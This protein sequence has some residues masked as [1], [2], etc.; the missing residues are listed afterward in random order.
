MNFLQLENLFQ[1]RNFDENQKKIKCRV[2]INFDETKEMTMAELLE[3]LGELDKGK[4]SE[5]IVP[6]QFYYNNLTQETR[7]GVVN[8]QREFVKFL[9]HLYC[10][11]RRIEIKME[12]AGY[13]DI[14]PDLDPDE[15]SWNNICAKLELA[16]ENYKLA[17]KYDYLGVYPILKE[18]FSSYIRY[19]RYSMENSINLNEDKC[20]PET[21]GAMKLWLQK[22]CIWI[23]AEFNGEWT[24][25]TNSFIGTP[26]GFDEV[27][28]TL[29]R[30]IKFSDYPMQN[31]NE[32]VEPYIGEENNNKIKFGLVDMGDCQPSQDMYSSR[33]LKLECPEKCTNDLR[34]WICTKCGEYVKFAV[35]V[36]GRRL[37]CNCGSQKYEKIIFTCHH[38]I[39][40]LQE[41][42]KGLDENEASY[43]STPGTIAIDD[44]T[45]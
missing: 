32:E 9:S 16:K 40:Q 17:D 20:L 35:G 44:E 26:D 33:L 4:H 36:N 42:V 45:P 7:Q 31:D 13:P 11:Y 19:I 21:A 10:F 38:P 41:P 24:N 30:T 39:H 12:N 18:L 27:I 6:V 25:Y 14:F 34:R 28:Q 2:L 37:L 5:Y 23:P 43:P 15:R 8:N 3:F 22:L 1:E 29:S